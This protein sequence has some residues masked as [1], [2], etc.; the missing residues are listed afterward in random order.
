MSFG[1][2]LPWAIGLVL[3]L[4]VG[5]SLVVAFGDRHAG[6]FFELASLAPADVWR[7]QVWRLV[8]WPFIEPGPIA[9]IFACLFVWWFGKDLADEWGSRRFLTVFGGVVLAAAVGTC[10]VAQAD[11]A[12]MDHSYLGGWALTTAMVVAWGLWFP[13]RVV[14]IYFVLPITGYWLAWLTIAVT[15]IFA[16]YS[17]WEGFLPELFAEGSILAWLFRRSLLARWSAA[18][19]GF[20]ARRRQ[21][22]RAQQRARSTAS[23]RLVEV[24]ED[25]ELPPEIEGKLR[26]IF[27]GKQKP[28]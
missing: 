7:G 5:L 20:E 27:E 14:R 11:P 28:R 8:T 17:G 21:A 24:H 26:D 3:S 12:V 6:S 9:L 16:V 10:L 4:I 23:L 25:D 18:R 15:V 22:R 2:R 1:G 13:T 19:A